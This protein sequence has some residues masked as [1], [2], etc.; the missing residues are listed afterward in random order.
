[1]EASLGFVAEQFD[2]VLSEAARRELTF[3]HFL[4]QLLRQAVR[5]Q[6]AEARHDRCADRG[7]ARDRPA[8]LSSVRASERAL[9]S[10]W[11]ARRYEWAVC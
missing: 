10:S 6:I 11:W 9:L 7:A 5:N 4:D 2:V 8:W 1:M 3:L